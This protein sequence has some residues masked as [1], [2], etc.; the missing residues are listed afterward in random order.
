MIVHVQY[1]NHK[2]NI[3]QLLFSQ[4]KTLETNPCHP[5]I[6]S[7]QPVT[8]GH[9]KNEEHYEAAVPWSLSE[10]CVLKDLSGRIER[11]SRLSLGVDISAEVCVFGGGVVM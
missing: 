8:D 10:T 5:L 6:H 9:I 3:I 7:P 2:Q 4:K 11:I 1:I